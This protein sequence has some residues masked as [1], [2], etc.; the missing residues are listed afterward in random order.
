MVL[1]TSFSLLAPFVDYGCCQHP[2]SGRLRRGPGPREAPG[3]AGQSRPHMLSAPALRRRCPGSPDWAPVLNP[4]AR[5]CGGGEVGAGRRHVLATAAAAG[6]GSISSAASSRAHGEPLL[7]P[8]PARPA[9]GSPPGRA[10]GRLRGR[11]RPSG[12]R[13]RRVLRPRARSPPPPSSWCGPWRAHHG[14]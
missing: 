13:T 10:A 6:E 1:T 14:D 4:G 11:P 3:R 12:W 8:A 9:R 5:L 2:R 7:L